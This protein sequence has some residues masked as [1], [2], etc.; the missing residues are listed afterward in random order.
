MPF[1]WVTLRLVLAVAIFTGAGIAAYY[2]LVF[3]PAV[4]GVNNVGLLSD[5]L[6]GV[7]CGCA[8]ALLA[9]LLLL[10]QVL[11]QILAELKNRK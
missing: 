4:S 10:L 2:G 11:R 5:R 9:A 3:D 7:I 1:E 8:L 6:S